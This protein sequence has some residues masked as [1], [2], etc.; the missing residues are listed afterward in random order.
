VWRFGC[1]SLAMRAGNQ[2]VALILAVMIVSF[3]A[4]LGGA[5]LTSATIDLWIGENFKG[6]TQSLYLAESGI[7]RGREFLRTSAMPA[8]DVVFVSG[9]DGVGTYQ[10]W[11]QS[12]APLILE[13]A[14]RV[15]T[16]RRTIQATLL[17]G[18]FPVDVSD[19]RLRTVTGLER[20]VR[21]VA[22]NCTDVFPGGSH[23]G[24]YGSPSDY[25]VAIVNGTATF[26]PGTGYG[27]LL[28]RG[29]LTI[30]GPYAWSGLV[31]VIGQGSIQY[32]ASATGLVRGGLFTAR[33]LSPSGAL[34]TV[35]G[36][37]SYI[38]NDIPA[39]TRA[40]ASFPYTPIAVREW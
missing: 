12:T 39:F 10:A 31:L 13:S 19:P 11:L 4:V 2:G 33:T 5:L 3:L 24:N 16:A 23:I 38:L 32:D 36:S 6:H 34:L 14:A 26:G 15:G 35:P 37:V 40:N 18:S 7:E 25:R 1:F 27:L 20:F 30:F 17:K 28:V 21:A 8:P 29:E 22:E 9:A